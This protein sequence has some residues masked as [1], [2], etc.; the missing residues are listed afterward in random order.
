MQHLWPALIIAWAL[1]GT[2]APSAAAAPCPPPAQAPTQQAVQAA[3]RN[4]QD[5]GFLWR[6]EKDSRV[7]YLF[8][9][10]HIAKFD[11][12]FPGPAVRRALLASDTVA[13]ELDMLDPSIQRRVAEA[14]TKAGAMPL[15]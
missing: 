9:T 14:M 10:V 12:M 15:S 5:R 13:L 8:G 6:V 2:A 3:M 4:A 7:S 11:W 1:A